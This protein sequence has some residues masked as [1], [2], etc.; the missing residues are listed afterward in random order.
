LSILDGPQGAQGFDPN[1]EERRE[2]GEMES[3]IAELRQE[4]NKVREE[5]TT[6]ESRLR[7]LEAERHE[8]RVAAA[9]DARM[10][11]GLVRDRRAEAE[12]LRELDASTL[13]LL[14]ED[15]DGIAWNAA[16][17]RFAA[18]K[19]SYAA[20]GGEFRAAVEE[21]RERLFGHRRAD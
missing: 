6:L 1:P 7:A 3:N 13:S 4:L 8:E 20:G 5:K 14:K 18:P 16:D 9:L 10:R 19:A 12:R 21:M 2:K 17:R 15:A 11:A